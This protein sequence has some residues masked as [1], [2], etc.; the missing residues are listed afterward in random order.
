MRVVLGWRVEVMGDEVRSIDVRWAETNLSSRLDWMG[1]SSLVQTTMMLQVAVMN[2]LLLILSSLALMLVE[3][4]ATVVDAHG[5]LL[6]TPDAA[7]S[8]S[9][10]VGEVNPVLAPVVCRMTWAAEQAVA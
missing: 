3:V 1:A 6:S 2:H 9:L 10:K 5:S 4:M 8:F 7:R